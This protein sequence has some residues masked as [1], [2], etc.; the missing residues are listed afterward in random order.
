MQKI[1]VGVLRGGPSSEYEISLKTGATVLQHLP[2]ETYETQDILISREG[3][4]HKNGLPI[5]PYDALSHV[6]V[7]FNAL[8]GHYGE[9]GKVQ[10]LLEILRIPFTG[11]LS[12]ASAIGMNKVLSK[13]VFKKEGIKTP[14]YQIVEKVPKEALPDFS[15]LFRPRSS[16]SLYLVDVLSEYLWSKLQPCFLKLSQK[17]LSMVT[18]S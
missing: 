9:D 7:I 13:E 5:I 3:I 2:R 4:W 6:D 12:F 10:H 1:R 17:H 16:S 8:H 15:H 14:Y 18:P 11:S